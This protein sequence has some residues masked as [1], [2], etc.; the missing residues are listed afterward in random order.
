[1]PYN[2]D[3][4]L[5]LANPYQELND[6]D[7]LAEHQEEL[8]SL[9]EEEMMSLATQLVLDCPKE[10]LTQFGRAILALRT[11]PSEEASFYSV[12][13]AALEVKKRII[14]LLDPR[15][16][17]PHRMLLAP[18]LAS[19]LFHQYSELAMGV[20]HTNEIAI[21]QRLA[22]STPKEKRS[23]LMRNVQN[24][25]EDSLFASKL[26]A[27]F[28]LVRNIELLLGDKPRDFFSSIEFNVRL[29][30]E[31]PAIFELIDHKEEQIAKQF[32]ETSLGMHRFALFDNIGQVFGEHSRLLTATKEAFKAHAEK[33][34]T[35][36][37]LLFTPPKESDEATT[38]AASAAFSY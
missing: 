8:D 16:E 15:N 31:F 36:P 35:N 7:A 5:K 38:K 3:Q 19:D 29:C 14:S 30:L 33:Y 13:S 34:A 20:L 26:G 27:A 18:E 12:L 21:A 28:T 32:A 6:G 4:L 23:E 9:S 17:H 22:L 37:S 25:F 24:T 1:M 10:E 11:Q 2:K